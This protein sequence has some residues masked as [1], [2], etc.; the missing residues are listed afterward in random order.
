MGN[1][2]HSMWF[3]ACI[4]EHFTVLQLLLTFPR[5]LHYFWTDFIPRE[6]FANLKMIEIIGILSKFLGI[7]L[8][9]KDFFYSSRNQVQMDFLHMTEWAS[10]DTDD[11]QRNVSSEHLW[12]PATEAKKDLKMSP[13]V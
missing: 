8:E 1:Q 12:K 13:L 6:Q 10:Q 2:I 3:T 9:S 7:K 5:K 4:N 11:K